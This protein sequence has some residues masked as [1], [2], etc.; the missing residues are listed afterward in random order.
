MR[1]LLGGFFV[2][3]TIAFGRN[4]ARRFDAVVSFVAADPVAVILSMMRKRGEASPSSD[5]VRARA[6][7]EC[8]AAARFVLVENSFLPILPVPKPL[9]RRRGLI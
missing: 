1:G 8:V 6:L 7:L 4:P 3:K 9:E 5:L 2:G